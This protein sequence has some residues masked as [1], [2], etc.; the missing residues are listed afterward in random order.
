MTTTAVFAN[1]CRRP[2]RVTRF[3]PV[4]CVPTAEGTPSSVANSRRELPAPL[5]E[6]NPA[7]QLSG[8][9]AAALSG[10]SGRASYA[11]RMRT[12]GRRYFGRVR[13]GPLDDAPARFRPCVTVLP[14]R[15]EARSGVFL[16][17]LRRAIF[18]PALAILSRRSR[19]ASTSTASPQ[20][21]IHG[22]I[23]TVP[24]TV[25]VMFSVPLVPSVSRCDGCQIDSLTRA[26]AGG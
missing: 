18:A 7:P 2:S 10:E 6:S 9:Q 8:H 3:V 20:P 17:E 5:A 24:V 13:D 14:A 26:D 23:S 1:A 25:T 12:R 16:A 21:R 22:V 15:A 11:A 19:G 4:R